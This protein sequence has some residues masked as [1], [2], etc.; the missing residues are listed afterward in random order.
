MMQT[1]VHDLASQ[2]GA[3]QALPVT[4]AITADTSTAVAQQEIQ[5]QQSLLMD[6]LTNIQATL[7]ARK[8]VDGPADSGSGLVSKVKESINE[9]LEAGNK[10]GDIGPL[11]SSSAD[12]INLVTLLYQ[13]IWKDESLPVVMKE[14]IGRTQISI[15]KVALT[16]TSFFENEQHPAR[17]IL[18]EFAMAG[19]AWTEAELLANDSV[20]QKIKELV[21]RI[22]AEKALSNTFFQKLINE[23]R[24]FK[25]SRSKTDAALEQ[26]IRETV[27]HSDRLEDVSAFVTQKIDERILNDDLDPSIRT[28]L[29]TNFHDFLVKLVLKEGPGGSSW[30]PV[31]STIDV[32]LWTVKSE[33]QPGDK[34]RFDKINPRLIDNLE[35]ALEIG[36]TSKSRITKIIRQLKQV[37]DFSFHQAETVAKRRLVPTTSHTAQTATTPAPIARKEPPPLPRDDPHLRQVDKFPIGIWLEF[38]GSGGQPVRCTLAAKIDSIDK[39]FFVNHQGVKVVELT[40]MRLARELKAGSVRIVSEGSLVD[41]AIESVISNLRSS[42]R[43]AEA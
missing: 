15:M 40:R 43:K 31:M 12:V 7:E 26:R 17:V 29:H 36:G 6:M 8:T 38:Q 32:L 2:Q 25:T 41:R 30:K 1:L 35:K 24:Q 18:N 10:S 16:D 13:A 9:S 3:A 22:L 33:K 23:L 34:E 42:A 27:D 11:D 39:M 4:A 21:E 5:K 14:L 19:I 37:Q 28:V 20:Y